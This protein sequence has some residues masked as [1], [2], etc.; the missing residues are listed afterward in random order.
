MYPVSTCMK[1]Q[2]LVFAVRK[3]TGSTVSF[4]VWGGIRAV[5]SSVAGAR[6]PSTP[7]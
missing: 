6:L 3:R 7:L 5:L 1:R 4:P 2:Y